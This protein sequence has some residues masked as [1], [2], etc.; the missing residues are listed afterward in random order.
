MPV[1]GGGAREGDCVLFFFRLSEEEK[2]ER[3]RLIRSGG[4]ELY[5]EFDFDVC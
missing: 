3:D 4:L 5:Q 1:N 2:M